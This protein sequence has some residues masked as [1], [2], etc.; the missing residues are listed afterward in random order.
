MAAFTWTAKHKKTGKS[1]GRFSRNPDVNDVDTMTKLL[2]KF[3]PNVEVLDVKLVEEEASPEPDGASDSEHA[4]TARPPLTID[5]KPATF[6]P[7]PPED[8]QKGAAAAARAEIAARSG[9]AESPE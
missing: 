5:G 9:E 2:R 4:E 1:G 6:S 7:I 3:F 8:F